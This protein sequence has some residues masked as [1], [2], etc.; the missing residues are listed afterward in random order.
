M[1][2]VVNS[3]QF[4]LEEL[5]DRLARGEAFVIT[6]QGRPV[7]RLMPETQTDADAETVEAAVQT[8]KSFRG[9]MAGVSVDELAQD[10][11]TGRRF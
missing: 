7:A 8:L 3:N 5:L 9:E 10:R 1:E 2:T 6:R 11:A 4:H